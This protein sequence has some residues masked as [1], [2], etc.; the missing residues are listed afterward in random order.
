MR[1]DS[2]RLF[3]RRITSIRH[4]PLT[5]GT[6]LAIFLVVTLPARRSATD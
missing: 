4:S 3:R 5:L 2:T 6:K 1:K